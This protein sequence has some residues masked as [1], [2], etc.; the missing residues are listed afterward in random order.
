MSYYMLAKNI[1]LSEII[2]CVFDSSHAA[3]FLGYLCG[4][5][6]TVTSHLPLNITKLLTKKCD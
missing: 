6:L 4:T 3:K 5:N 1:Y 2:V